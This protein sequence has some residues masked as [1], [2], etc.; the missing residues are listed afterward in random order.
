MYVLSVYPNNRCLSRMVVPGVHSAVDSYQI[1]LCLVYSSVY[2]YMGLNKIND[3]GFDLF[4]F[5]VAFFINL[6]EVF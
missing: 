3:I 5:L 2:I 6:L 4:S 1:R